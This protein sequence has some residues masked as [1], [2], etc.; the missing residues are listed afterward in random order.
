MNLKEMFYKKEAKVITE[1]RY[2]AGKIS[3]CTVI[4]R[5]VTWFSCIKKSHTQI[6]DVD[7]VIIL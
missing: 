3:R 5:T 4:D 6:I 2:F 1:Y 7:G